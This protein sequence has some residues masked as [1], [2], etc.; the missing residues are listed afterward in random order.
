MPG[1]LTVVDLRLDKREIISYAEQSFFEAFSGTLQK[2]FIGVY[3]RPKRGLEAL[4]GPLRGSQRLL[5]GSPCNLV[6]YSEI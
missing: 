2:T 4:T 3:L 1:C 5:M 6:T